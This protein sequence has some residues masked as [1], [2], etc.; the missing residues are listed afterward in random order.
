MEGGNP[1]EFMN[2]CILSEVLPSKFK[3]TCAQSIFKSKQWV[4]KF[5]EANYIAGAQYDSEEEEVE[6]GE[7]ED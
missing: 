7:E 1:T 3:D 6:P 5:T 4:D 2:T